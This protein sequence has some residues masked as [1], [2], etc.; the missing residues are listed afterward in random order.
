MVW[1]FWRR[2]WWA[3]TKAIKDALSTVYDGRRKTTYKMR[4]M[5]KTNHTW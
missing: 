1:E 5:R 4:N 2:D 3:A